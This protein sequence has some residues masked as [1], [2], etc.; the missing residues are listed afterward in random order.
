MYLSKNFAFHK[1]Y[2]KYDFSIKKSSDE[3]LGKEALLQ[4]QEV[5]LKRRFTQFLL[6]DFDV[7]QDIWP[8]GGE[9]IYRDGKFVG[10]T[11]TCG[12]G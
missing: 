1:P 5:G 3:F 7:H 4:Q 8:W 12:Y 2:I 6:D 11:T 9:P 10:M